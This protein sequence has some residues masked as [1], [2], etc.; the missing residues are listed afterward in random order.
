[1]SVFQQCQK[2]LTGGESLRPID[3]LVLMAILM[4]V[5]LKFWT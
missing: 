1:M 4:I 2:V 3:Y 5:F